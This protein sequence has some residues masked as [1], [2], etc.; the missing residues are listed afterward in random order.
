MEVVHLKNDTYQVVSTSDNTVLYQGSHDDCL[1][2]LAYVEQ[3]QY[4]SNFGGQ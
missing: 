2:Y 3:Q 1:G 4:E